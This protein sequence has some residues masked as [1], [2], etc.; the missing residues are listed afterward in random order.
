LNACLAAGGTDPV[1]CVPF[2]RISTGDLRPPRNFLANLGRITTDGEDLKI[3]WISTPTSIGRLSANFQATRVNGYK[4][5][6][7]DGNVAQRRVG[8]EVDNSAIPNTQANTQLG[9]ALGDWQVNW[10]VRYI[11]SV[12]EACGNAVIADV[13]GCNAGEEFNK[14][15]A[16]FYN[17]AQLQWSNAF[18]VKGMELQAGVNNVFGENAPVC[19]TCTLNGYDAGTYDLPGA[20]WYAQARF[21]F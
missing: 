12:K 20:F 17:D 18:A 21:R 14:L 2:T 11:S 10:T 16:T 15:D 4:A 8:I 9:L 19:Y 6:D 13:P 1:L 3:N 7:A 5:V